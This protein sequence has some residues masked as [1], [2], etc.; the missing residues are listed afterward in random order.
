ME[1]QSGEKE[2]KRE[3]VTLKNG[4]KESRETV[5]KVVARRRG[6]SVTLGLKTGR[7]DAFPAGA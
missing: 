5:G 2:R 4:L 7:V 1:C 6:G 3:M